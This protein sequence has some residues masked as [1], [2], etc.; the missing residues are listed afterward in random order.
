MSV[1]ETPRV[2]PF[3]AVTVLK[4]TEFFENAATALRAKILADRTYE[5][6]SG[7]SQRQL[8]DIGLGE[9]DLAAFSREISRRGL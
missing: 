4:I 3:G 9:V 1:Y 5:A 8:Q 6:L 7:L 2:A